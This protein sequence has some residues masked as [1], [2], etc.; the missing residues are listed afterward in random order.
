MDGGSRRGGFLCNNACKQSCKTVPRWECWG[1]AMQLSKS[2]VPL[3]PLRIAGFLCRRSLCFPFS[4]SFYFLSSYHTHV[5]VVRPSSPLF[6][7]LIDFIPFTSFAFPP[8]PPPQGSNCLRWWQNCSDFPANSVM[9]RACIV[10]WEV[11]R[12]ELTAWWP[13]LP[14][15]RE[16]GEGGEGWLWEQISLSCALYFVEEVEEGRG[17]GGWGDE[18]GGRGEKA[19]EKMK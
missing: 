7:L 8:S 4:T 9:T 10:K 17:G 5:L 1:S 2:C 12:G 18:R 19:G 16:R 13:S 6:F 11:S 3:S 14:W 15:G